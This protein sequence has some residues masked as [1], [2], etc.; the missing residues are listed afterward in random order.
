MSKP[1]VTLSSMHTC[2][3]V[4]AMIP[5]VGGPII[6]PGCIGILANGMPI[7]VMGDQCVC[8]GPPDVVIEGCP[9]VLANG[10]PITL[11]G[12]KTAHGGV[13]V[14]G[15]V[16]ITVTSASSSVYPNISDIPFPKR[17]KKTRKEQ[18]AKKAKEE[19]E[20]MKEEIKNNS[21]LPDIDFSV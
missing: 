4:N 15:V 20:E 10:M 8:T 14:Q 9:G 13:V 7:S 1:I 11:M 2:P 12:S 19:Q 21:F 17:V 6:G 3:L 18:K 5:H 16:G